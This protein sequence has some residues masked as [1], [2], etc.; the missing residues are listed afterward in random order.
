MQNALNLLYI[1]RSSGFGQENDICA[2]AALA[3]C[4]MLWLVT[5]PAALWPTM[6]WATAP[7]MAVIT[8]ILLGAY[9][10]LPLNLLP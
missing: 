9:P 6:G 8:F 7:A 1:I 3:R 2:L 5:L 4:M 10:S